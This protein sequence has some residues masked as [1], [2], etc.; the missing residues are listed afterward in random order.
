MKT[1]NKIAELKDKK[2]ILTTLWI[3]YMFN[4]AYIDIT[5]LYYSVFINH[6]PTVHYTQVFLLGGGILVEIPV[7]AIE[8]PG[9]S[10]GEHHRRHSIDCCSDRD[11]VCWKADFG[12]PLLLNHI[13]CHLGVYCLVCME[14]ATYQS[15]I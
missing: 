3:F 5:T 6:A 13:D 14:M 11:A 4:T 8:V 1:T 12:L 15:A 10:L 9:K 2:L 7:S